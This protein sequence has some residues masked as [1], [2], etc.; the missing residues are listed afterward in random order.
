MVFQ[1]LTVF[2][3]SLAFC[4]QIMAQSVSRAVFKEKCSGMAR[5]LFQGAERS[6]AI[7]KV[8][9]KYI[10]HHFAGLKKHLPY[11]YF[12]PFP[13]FIR[14]LDFELVDLKKGEYL[15]ELE[16]SSLSI[17]KSNEEKLALIEAI[18]EFVSHNTKHSE[19]FVSSFRERQRKVA[20]L[21]NKWKPSKKLLSPE[22]FK[23][24]VDQHHLWN[25]SSFFQ[26]KHTGRMFH[27]SGHVAE[28]ARLRWE[29]EVVKQSSLRAMKELNMVP[30]VEYT[31]ERYK[32]TFGS[33]FKVLTLFETPSFYNF[34]LVRNKVETMVSEG[35]FLEFQK[36]FKKLE[37][38]EFY[39]DS[40][41]LFIPYAVM[42]TIIFATY[43][44]VREMIEI[45]QREQ[46]LQ[47]L[48]GLVEREE[49]ED[50]LVFHLSV[51]AEA[52]LGEP[53]AQS[54]LQEFRDYLA[55]LKLDELNDVKVKVEGGDHRPLLICVVKDSLCHD[56]P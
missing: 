51:R 28:M 9:A 49:V 23:K 33:I 17:P 54:G 32:N 55:S 36:R 6:K 10:G 16:T 47:P 30:D 7:A 29:H 19:D 35:S 41:V 34:W 52:L 18:I 31:W 12:L 25:H 50:W 45:A 8:S 5:S 46:A 56:D 24:I 1:R 40:T 48:T 15:R 39:K 11:F 42:G 26:M 4:G 37:T 3:L 13:R 44:R 53:Y 20:K 21:L 27:P 43:E 14:K 2:F 38:V 22:K